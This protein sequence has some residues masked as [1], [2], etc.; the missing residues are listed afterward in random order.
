MDLVRTPRLDLVATTVEPGVYDHDA[1]RF[2]RARLLEGGEAA[3]GW[4]SW[5]AF[6]R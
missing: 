6:A 5:Y 2:F 1:M 3:S 4:Y